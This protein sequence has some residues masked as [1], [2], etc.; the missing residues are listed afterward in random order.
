ML[1]GER[2]RAM[3][4]AKKLS[5]GDVEPASNSAGKGL[6]RACVSRVE[7]GHTVPAIE[8]LERFARA[9]EVPIYQLFYEG[10][11]TVSVG[12]GAEVLGVGLRGCWRFFRSLSFAA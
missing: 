7:N 5:Q 11:G 1:I 10:G 6:L 2:L 8:R 3:R 9:L 12:N 4:V